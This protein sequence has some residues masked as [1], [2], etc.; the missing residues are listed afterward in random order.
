MF[1]AK[2]GYIVQRLNGKFVGGMEGSTVS[3]WQGLFAFSFFKVF[4]KHERQTNQN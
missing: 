1:G 3:D 4:D 2:L